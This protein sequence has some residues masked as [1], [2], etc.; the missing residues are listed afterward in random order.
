M[1]TINSIYSTARSGLSVAQNAAALANRNLANVSTPGYAREILPIAAA[2]GGLGVTSG[3]PLAMRSALLERALQA[4]TG[5]SSFHE[6]QISHLTIAEEAVNDLDG[7]GLGTSIE[8][9]RTAIG[10]LAAHPSGNVE[11]EAFLSASEA[12]GDAFASTRTQL[13][14]A[15]SGVRQGAADVV[16]QVND[17]ASQIAR[18]DQRVRS[19]R[20]GDEKNTYIAQRTALVD[21]LSGLVDI[22]VRSANDGTI[23]VTTAGGR[24]LVDAGVASKMVV[25]TAPPPESTLSIGF[26]RPDGSKLEAIEGAEFGGALGGLLH[27]HAETLMPALQSLDALAFDFVTTFNST[28]AAGFTPS[29]QPGGDLF[30]APSSVAGA[31]A[32]VSLAAGFKA[33]DIA[34]A[35]DPSAGSGD[36]SNLLR[37]ADI[38]GQAGQLPGGASLP[39]TWSDISSGISRALSTTTSSAAFETSSRD[40]LQNLLASETGVSIDEE[41]FNLT[42]AQTALEASSKVIATAQQMTD[43]VLSLIG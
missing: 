23:T 31:A 30:T 25:S 41:M 10:A 34:G 4:A 14:S 40:Q 11:R 16:S 26:E 15:A 21:T 2:L 20:P 22:D 7:V 18:V 37:L 28:H 32:N 29:G 19:A 33:S 36:N 5:R 35:S 43:T 27:V 8:D 9:F 12:L 3:A 24:G 17:L 1:A 6:S 42:L 13:D 38:A 39:S